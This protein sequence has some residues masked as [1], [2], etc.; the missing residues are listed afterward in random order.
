VIVLLRHGQTEWSLAGKHTGAT[1]VPLTDAGREQARDARSRLPTTDFAHV[2]VSPRVR[3]QDTADLAG[4]GAGKVTEPDLVE[5]DYGEYEGVTTKEIHVERPD[6]F[7]WTDGCPGG[8][9]PPQVT[10]RVDRLLDRVRPLCGDGDVALVAHGHVLRAIG[11][12]W[13]RQPIELG[14]QLELGT[15][16][17]CG[18]GTEHGRPALA[19]WN[20]T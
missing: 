15:A 1:D 13:M 10:E 12:R 4:I 17:V 11:A 9:S 8:E 19:F 18:L 14:G 6:W 3:A 20:L 5:W 7:L 2:L 16:A